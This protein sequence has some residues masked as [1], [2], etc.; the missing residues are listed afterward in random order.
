MG[1]AKT[2]KVS[3][4]KLN[5]NFI[6]FVAE[7]ITKKLMSKDKTALKEMYIETLK[8]KSA[9]NI[10]RVCD[11]TKREILKPALE[12]VLKAK[13]IEFEQFDQVSNEL[14]AKIREKKSSNYVEVAAK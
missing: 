4:V 9:N 2:E 14:V 8:L 11:R 3:K 10:H 5:T 6:D 13:G 1:K 7:V 12:K